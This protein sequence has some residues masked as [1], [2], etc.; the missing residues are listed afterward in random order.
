MTDAQQ[1]A[2]MQSLGSA[3]AVMDYAKQKGLSI[4]DLARIGGVSVQE[5]AKIAESQ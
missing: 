1:K 2:Y 3:Q 5:M 4:A